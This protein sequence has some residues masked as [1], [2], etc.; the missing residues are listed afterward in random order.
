M[1]VGLLA[2]RLPPGTVFTSSAELHVV[3]R[4]T[5]T[6]ISASRPGANHKCLISCSEH[7]G[8]GFR[9]GS[10]RCQSV[11]A[12]RLMKNGTAWNAGKAESGSDTN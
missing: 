6:Y 7:P 2:V 3:L 12:A 1:A 4:Q 11:A 8:K 9:V 10:I 5:T